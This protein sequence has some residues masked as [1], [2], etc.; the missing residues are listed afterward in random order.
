MKVTIYGTNCCSK[1]SQVES[2]V[3]TVIKDNDLDVEYKKVNDSAKAIK[4]GIMS[5]PAI[6]V[7]GEVKSK[8]KVPTRERIEEYLNV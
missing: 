2:I 6:V 3:K 4:E 8:G 1:C 5:L 7:D